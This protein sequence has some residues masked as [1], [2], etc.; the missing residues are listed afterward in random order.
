MSVVIVKRPGQAGEPPGPSR[1]TLAGPSDARLRAEEAAKFSRNGQQICAV[2]AP[3]LP[4]CGRGFAGW[5][6][7]SD[8]SCGRA[9]SAL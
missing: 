3:R 9:P 2:G 6:C 8:R 4:G 1:G 5:R 7:S